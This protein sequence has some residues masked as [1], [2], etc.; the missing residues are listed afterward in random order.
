MQ[1]CRKK[2]NWILKDGRTGM[3]KPHPPF[4]RFFFFLVFTRT[5]DLGC[6]VYSRET[7]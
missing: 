1:K 3:S 6:V 7:R 4:F 2:K 5:R